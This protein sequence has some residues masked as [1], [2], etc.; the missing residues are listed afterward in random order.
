MLS[1]I[2]A[3]SL[4]RSQLPALNPPFKPTRNISG[5]LKEEGKKKQ[6]KQSLGD[7]HHQQ[8]YTSTLEAWIPIKWCFTC[9]G[10]HKMRR[11]PTFF[12]GAF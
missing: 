4:L 11:S 12:G 8:N 5:V 10:S 9:S 6:K 3:T 7:Q 2:A 1:R